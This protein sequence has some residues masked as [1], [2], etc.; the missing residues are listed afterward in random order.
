MG[1]WFGKTFLTTI[2]TNRAHLTQVKWQANL[3]DQR[4]TETCSTP[5]TT[6]Q[7]FPGSFPSTGGLCDGT[8]TDHYKEP[9]TDMSVE[10]PNFNPTIPRSTKNDL[11]HHMKPNCNEKYRHWISES[12]L[13]CSTERLRTLSG[14]P[15]NV[16]CNWYGANTY[17]FLEAPDSSPGTNTMFWL[18]ILIG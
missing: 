1:V 8:D 4:N 12:V 10:Q 13:V 16:L 17:L 3:P 2:E 9:H 14:N 5:E 6:R 15:R 7:S 11:R 18:L